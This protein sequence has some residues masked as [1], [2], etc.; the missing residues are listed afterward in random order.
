MRERTRRLKGSPLLIVCSLLFAVV[1]LSSAAAFATISPPVMIPLVFRPPVAT[2]TPTSSPTLTP[3]PTSIYR[4]AQLLLNGSFED[5]F[6]DWLVFGVPEICST[7]SSHGQH[8]VLLRDILVAAPDWPHYNGRDALVQTIVVP[9]WA[10]NAEV[11][12]DWLVVVSP[13][14][15]GAEGM[16]SVEVRCE[17]ELYGSHFAAPLDRIPRGIWQSSAFSFSG[18]EPAD[19]LIFQI[20]IHGDGNPSVTWYLDNASLTF[21]SSTP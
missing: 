10:E 2:A 6:S 19:I 21:Y 9:A 18:F 12:A 16:L 14:D 4:H 1:G 15:P 3:T 7:Q 20:T 5:G 8:S 13:P 11:A 17:G